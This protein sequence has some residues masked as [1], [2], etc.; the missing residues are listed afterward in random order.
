MSEAIRHVD[1]F[2]GRIAQKIEVTGFCWHW[3]G[4]RNPQGY[5]GIRIDGKHRG[6]HRVVYEMLVGPIPTGLEL[7]HLCRVRH[8]VNP[9]HLEPVSH[10]E[11][12]RRSWAPTGRQVRQTHCK[13]GHALTPENLVRHGVK[14]GKRMCLTCSRYQNSK[15]G[16][17]ERTRRKQNV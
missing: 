3:I 7:D 4:F 14:R 10:R 8:C 5:G 11:N 9:D 16:K 17:L 15:A 1:S 13:W 12:M 6:A 2:P